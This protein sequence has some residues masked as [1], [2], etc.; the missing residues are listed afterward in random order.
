MDFPHIKSFP[1]ITPYDPGDSK[2]FKV[3]DR[4]IDGELVPVLFRKGNPGQS[5]AQVAELRRKGI[6]L[7]S[8]CVLPEFNQR[9]YIATQFPPHIECA[10]DVAVKLR[11]GVTIYADIYRPA[12]VEEP[13]PLIV[14]WGPFGKRP[15]EGQD[16]WKLMGVPPGTVSTMAK[17]E[18]ADPGY[19]CRHGYAVA[20]VDPR[21]I[22]HSEGDA[23]CWGT[24]DGRDGYD[25]IEWAAAQEW[26]NSRVTLFGNSGV[27]MVIWRIAAEQPPH[28]ACIAAWEATGDMY[29]ESF[30]NAGIPRPGFDEMICSACTVPNYIEDQPNMLSAHPFYDSYW[31]TKTPKWSQIRV[32]A[33]VCAGLC[34]FHLRGSFE[35]FRKIRSPKK[36]FRVHRDMEWPDTY[37]NKNIEDLRRFYDRYLKDERNGWEMTPRVRMDVMDAFDFD[38]AVRRPEDEFPLA[39]T[40]YRKLYL[41]AARRTMSYERSQAK[42]EIEYDGKTGKATFGIVFDEETEIV[43]YIKLRLYIECRGYDNMDMFF[44]LKKYQDGNYIPVHCMKAPY[45]GAWG[46]A[47]GRRRELDANLSTDERPVLA[48]LRDEPMEPGQ[49]YPIDIEIWPHSR[50]WHKGEELR[51]EITPEF[52]KTDWYE[53]GHL[54]FITDNGNGRHVIHTGGDYD[55]YLQIPFIKPKYRSGEYIYRG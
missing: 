37:D 5:A 9:T 27:A 49:I 51:L 21:G 35:G 36:W 38:Y 25:F 23:Q 33:Y 18:S 53:D 55:S 2:K 43:G 11:D 40:E 1:G 13:L 14:S 46:Y 29:R 47:R 4:E 50:I 28:L 15:A 32:P 26:C 44:W 7:P 16:E 45:R 52:V 20:N 31:E 48:H 30:T 39:R 42:A 6:E 22:G 10:Q 8:F 41:D 24:E 19:W 17:F 3:V 12:G 34:H 54:D